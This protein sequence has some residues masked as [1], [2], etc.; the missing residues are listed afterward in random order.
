[1]LGLLDAEV[2]DVVDEGQASGLLEAPFQGAFRNP[3]VPDDARHHAGL[4][5]ALPEPGLA[6]AH[7]GVGVRLRSNERGVR[8]LALVVPLQQVD[9]RNTHRLARAHVPRDD[10]Q[11]E[12]VPRRRAACRHDAAG[13][14]GEAEVGLRAETH[15]RVL[16]PEEILVAPV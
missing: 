5:E 15:L 10:V 1:M 12:V 2:L 8:Q 4:P 3:R 14:V 11:R 6:A 16:A 7:H 13:R 9:L